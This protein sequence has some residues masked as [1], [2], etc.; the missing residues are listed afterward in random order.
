[1]DAAGNVD[2]TPASYSWTIQSPTVNCGTQ[3]TLTANGRRLDRLRAAR[4]ANKGSDSILK[5]MSKSGGNLRA[6]V[7]FNLPTMPQ[8]CSVESATLRIYA[9]SAAGGRTLAGLPARRH[10]DRGRRDLGEPAGDD[11]QRRRRR[12][13]APA[14]A[15]GTSPAMVQAHV[16]GR[17]QRL[18]RPR[19]DREPGRRAAVPQPRGRAP[20][21]RSSCCKFGTGAPP[22]RPPRPTRQL[23]GTPAG[24]RPRAAVGDVHLHRHRRRDAGGQPDLRVPA[25]RAPT[26]RRGPRARPRGATRASPSARTPSA[27][28]PIDA[29]GNVDP[30]AGRLHLDDRPDGTRRRSSPT[31]RR[32]RRPARARRFAVPRRPRPARRSS[33]RS[34]P[35]PF[36]A[37]T[38]PKAYTGLAVGQ[39]TFQV[40]ATDAA[41]NVDQTPASYPWTIQPGGDPVE[42]RRRADRARRS[43][44]RGSSRAARRANKGARLDPQG[45]VQERERQPAGA[46]PVRPADDP[47]GLRRRHGHAAPV[48]GLRLGEPAHAPGLPARRLVD[49]RAA[50]RGRTS[51]RRRARRPRRRRAPDT[52]SGTSPRIVQAMYSSGTNNG[53]LIRDATEGQ[54]AEQQFHAARRARTRR[55]S[56]SRSSPRPRD[57]RR[58]NVLETAG[59]RGL[60]C[61][62]RAS[63]AAPRHGRALRSRAAAR[64]VRAASLSRSSRCVRRPAG[65]R[66]GARRAERERRSRATLP[67]Q[68]TVYPPGAR[69][70]VARREQPTRDQGLGRDPQ[71]RGR[72]ARR[73]HRPCERPRAGPRPFEA[74]PATAAWLRC[75]TRAPP[76]LLRRGDGGRAGRGPRPGGRLDESGAT[77]DNQP[78][79]VGDAVTTWSRDGY[80]R[81]EGHRDRATDARGRGEPRFPVARRRRGHRGGWRRARLQRAR[82]GRESGRSSSSACA[83]GLRWTAPNPR[84]AEPA[85]VACGQVLTASTLVTNDL[86]E[87]PADGLVIGAAGI[88]VDLGGHTVDGVGLGSGVP[89]DGHCV[90]DRPKRDHA[91]VRLRGATL[92]RDDAQRRRGPHLTANEVAAVELF[93]VSASEVRGN[94]LNGNGGGILLVSGTRD[95]VVEGN[96]VTT[97]GGAGVLVRDATAT[98]SRT[99]ASWMAATSVSA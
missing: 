79:A 82:E 36:T 34:T 67:R 46:G 81:V 66:R 32:R 70:H 6:L 43:P 92:P 91:G 93:D 73:R 53:F 80:M 10:L 27:C 44:T 15:S 61:R 74:P 29:A 76:G 88:V 64:A 87:C 96:T 17:E 24:G 3:Q 52:A 39:H 30:H 21:G 65:G 50:S 71:R 47:G 1:M 58:A 45:H 83:A 84:A 25:R 28:G 98:G 20:T 59:G 75:R 33:A 5:V 56:S 9:K 54:D 85:A 40:R 72:I 90:C 11:R 13:R 62:R 4:R 2:L 8:G 95:C 38:S 41:G 78:A 89:I 26:P 94:S 35:A 37:C 55:S 57:G 14:T 51:R 68:P 69:R 23:T 86:S 12:P 63:C 18:P 99:T 42:L 49:A 60:D 31:A 16:H 97:N 48:R 7:R 77:W 22:P 19:R